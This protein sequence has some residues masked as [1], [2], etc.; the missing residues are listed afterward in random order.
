VD[1]FDRSPWLRTV[2]LV[3]G[4]Y[5]L[6]GITFALLAGRA[7]S[8]HARATW[9]LAAWVLSAVVF[10]AH[11]WFEHL[12]RRAPGTTALHVSLAVA[13]GAFVLALA[14]LAHPHAPVRMSS[15]LLALVLWPLITAVP[16]FLAALV[17]AA[18]LA[19]ARTS[20]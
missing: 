10:A 3:G 17:A 2:L 12:R 18:V 8:I 15:H 4:A 14:A 5:L 11:T 19:R 7:P 6:I 9:R 20:V 16:A 1:A 13:V